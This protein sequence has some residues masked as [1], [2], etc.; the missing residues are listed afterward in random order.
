MDDEMAQEALKRLTKALDESRLV[1]FV[2]AGI[3]KNSNLPSWNDLIKPMAEKLGINSNSKLDNMDFLK[4]PEILYHQDKESYQN[5]LKNSLPTEAKSNELDELII[6]LSPHHIVTTNYD[7]LLENVSESSNEVQQ[8][9][10]I[11]DDDTFSKRSSE[12][13]QYLIKMH[14]DLSNYN[15]I[16][17]KD[18][19]YLDYSNTHILISNFIK[20]LLSTHIFLFV[21]YSLG[22]NNLKLIQNWINYIRNQLNQN[23]SLSIERNVLL[24]SPDNNGKYSPE[25]EATYFKSQNIDLVDLSN[26]PENIQKY[27]KESTLK[28]PVAK[29]IYAF[30]QALNKRQA[31]QDDFSF[32]NRQF[33]NLNYVPFRDIVAILAPNERLNYGLNNVIVSKALYNAFEMEDNLKVPLLARTQLRYISYRTNGGKARRGK[34]NKNSI[35][36]AIFKNVVTNKYNNLAYIDKREKISGLDSAYIHYILFRNDY[37]NILSNFKTS[38]IDNY[39]EFLIKAANQSSLEDRYFGTIFGNQNKIQELSSSTLKNIYLRN[40]LELKV[41]D[42][43]MTR[44]LK[45]Q[46]DTYGGNGFSFSAEDIST[47]GKLDGIRYYLYDLYKYIRMNRIFIDHSAQNWSALFKPYVEAFLLTYLNSDRKLHFVDN[48]HDYPINDFDVDIMVKFFKYDELRNLFIKHKIELLKFQSK[49]RLISNFMNLCN[50]IKELEEKDVSTQEKQDDMYLKSSLLNYLNVYAL[51]MAHGEFTDDELLSICNQMLDMSGIS[52]L[53]ARQGFQEFLFYQLVSNKKNKHNNLKLNRFLLR[54]LSDPTFLPLLDEMDNR[55]LD[56]LRIRL[57]NSYRSIHLNNQK[58][59]SQINDGIQSP[60]YFFLFFGIAINLDVP[61]IK[62]KKNIDALVKKES[63]YIMRLVEFPAF[64]KYRSLGF[65]MI[66]NQIDKDRT[67]EGMIRS[68]EPQ[69]QRI[70]VIT[71]L[72]A[73]GYRYQKQSFRK[74]REVNPI[75]DFFFNPDKFDYSKVDLDSNAWQILIARNLQGMFPKDK[76]FIGYIKKHKEQIIDSN[77]SK[78]DQKFGIDVALAQATTIVKML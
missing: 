17:L 21:G 61:K 15:S 63:W 37:M 45:V 72:I 5:I 3:S 18:S 12:S 23:G 49:F 14:G 55:V 7:H 47:Y 77:K 36:D 6:K 22:D 11:Y 71:F 64:K 41:N 53:F 65:G 75:L 76:R 13:S 69:D 52:I 44:H 68:P 38:K 78:I 48:K 35:S 9:T 66:I 31:Y 39:S 42:E 25:E 19:D 32:V 20:S 50:S 27:S 28:Y 34:I 2:G 60:L 59:L 43:T 16:V 74:I 33:K 40:F 46:R 70:D 10:V 62:I 24:Y 67:P 56:N 51:V 29:N 1:I 30:L 57:N 54:K 73:N 4:I 58:I 26:L 8:Y